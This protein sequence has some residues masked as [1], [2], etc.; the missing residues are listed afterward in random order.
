M[1]TSFTELKEKE[2]VNLNDGKKLGRAID[3]V[4]DN[5]TGK[6]QGI[7]LPGDRK[8]FHK[9][10]N[11]FVPLR[12]LQKIGDDVILVNF[13]QSLNSPT[14]AKNV[15]S[16]LNLDRSVRQNLENSASIASNSQK[17]FIR[18]RRIDNSK[19]K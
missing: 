3:I 6:V 14:Y 10:D 8:L 19:Y 2:I 12:N 9:A 1:E 13:Y 11:I 17:S 18:Y 4:F 16:Q 15:A 5:Q 7:M